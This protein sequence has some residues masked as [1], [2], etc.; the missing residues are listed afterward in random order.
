MKTCKYTNCEKPFK[1]RTNKEF[2]CIKC[3][4][5][6]AKSV[7][8]DN[9]KFRKEKDNIYEILSKLKDMEGNNELINLYQKIYSK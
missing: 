6:H 2:C 8:R 1:G 9:I 7:Q 5:N 3:K 4:R